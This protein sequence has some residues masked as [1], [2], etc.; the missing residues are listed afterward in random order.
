MEMVIKGFALNMASEA[1][2]APS[3]SVAGWLMS[4]ISSARSLP[5]HILAITSVD[6]AE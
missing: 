1:A 4:K 5:S 2:I 6:A 3:Q